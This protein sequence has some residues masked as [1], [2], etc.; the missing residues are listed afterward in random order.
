MKNEYYL[1]PFKMIPRKLWSLYAN[2]SEEHADS[3]LRV[4]YH[5]D[6]THLGLDLFISQYVVGIRAAEGLSQDGHHI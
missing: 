5:A 6:S 3:I 2:I 1:L 4:N